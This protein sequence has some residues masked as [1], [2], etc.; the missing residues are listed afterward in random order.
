ML[1]PFIV[2]DLNLF[3][4]PV[5]API[6]IEEVYLKDETIPPN[7]VARLTTSGTPRNPAPTKGFHVIF[8]VHGF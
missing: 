1:E 6:M 5:M 3:P 2:Q 7:E 8:L 4:D